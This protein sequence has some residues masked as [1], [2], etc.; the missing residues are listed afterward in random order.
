M[1]PGEYIPT[2]YLKYNHVRISPGGDLSF[3]LFPFYLQSGLEGELWSQTDGG[4]NLSFTLTGCM[5]I[6]KLLL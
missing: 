2:L 1:E 6:D 5:D 3:H 4:S